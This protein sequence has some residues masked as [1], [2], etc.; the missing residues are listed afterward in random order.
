MFCRELRAINGILEPETATGRQFET[1]LLHTTR[2]IQESRACRSNADEYKGQQSYVHRMSKH[3]HRLHYKI[4]S[5]TRRAPPR[6]DAAK[7]N[8]SLFR[9]TRCARWRRVDL[10]TFNTYDDAH[11]PRMNELSEN[12][13]SK[14]SCNLESHVYGEAYTQLSSS[15]KTH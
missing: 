10:Q 13:H 3:F 11:F 15:T 12:R 2:T 7:Y 6:S 9:C 1:D 4:D 14:Q 5:T 8:V